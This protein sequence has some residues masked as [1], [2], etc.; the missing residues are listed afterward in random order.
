MIRI[1]TDVKIALAIILSLAIATALQ[2]CYMAAIPGD[3]VQAD[4]LIDPYF[5]MHLGEVIS[6][7]AKTE[8]VSMF[9]VSERY[10]PN[11]QSR[12]VVYL[13]AIL[14][15]LLPSWYCL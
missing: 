2:I 12:G 10:Q 15:R 1:G 9:A 11:P 4:Y 6:K 3:D 7:E 14:Y 13:T 8:H 5:Y